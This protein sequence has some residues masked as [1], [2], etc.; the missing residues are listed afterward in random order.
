MQKAGKKQKLQ[1]LNILNAN[2]KQSVY[3]LQSWRATVFRV[4]SRA[5]KYKCNCSS[6]R[7][8]YVSK[9]Q[10]ENFNHFS[11]ISDE[12]PHCCIH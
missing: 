12:W 9:T 11:H 7:L 3:F 5:I 4:C 8:Q 1:H 6:V 10:N 2:L